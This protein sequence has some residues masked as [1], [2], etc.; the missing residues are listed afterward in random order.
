MTNYSFEVLIPEG[1]HARP[2]AKL[3]EILKPFAP[4]DITYNESVIKNLSI[5]DLLLQKIP[6]GS[7]VTISTSESLPAEVT[8][9]LQNVF[10]DL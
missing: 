8:E 5:L 9:K 6:T 3:I 1:L 7:T 10:L 4:V 2:C